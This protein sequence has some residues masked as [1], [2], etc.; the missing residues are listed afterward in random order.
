MSQHSD[1][2][3]SILLPTYNRANLLERCV[4]S[5]L[6]QSYSN[7]ELIISDDRSTDDTPLVAKKIA[8]KD[9]RIRYR[10]NSTRQGCYANRN[11]AI[12]ISN[13]DLIFM[14]EDDLTLEPDCIEI[15]VK[16]YEDLKSKDINV[17]A[18]A[19]RWLLGHKK[20]QV[21]FKNAFSYV[22]KSKRKDKQEPCWLDIKTGIA[23]Q[24]FEIDLD[25]VQEVV[26][27]HACS[28][29]PK[30]VIEEV[31]GYDKAYYKGT[32]LGETDLSFRIKRKGYKQYF[33]PKAI[34]HHKR[35]DTGGLSEPSSSISYYYYLIRNEI[36]FR[37]KIFGM[38]SL[39]MI[40]A[41]LL[42]IIFNFARYVFASLV[43]KIGKSNNR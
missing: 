14:I 37:I 16:T 3:V 20:T 26:Y 10:R 32:F 35:S 13:G 8:K 38:K 29:F 19:P 41:F 27:V 12:S 40:P 2:F 42:F 15:L 7:W 22:G 23:Y 17:G 31:E 4:D 11:I 30:S 33:Q 9:A 36:I 21:L 1:L 24:N 34:E 28:L 18:I 6:A 5:I 43:N 25:N 39:Y